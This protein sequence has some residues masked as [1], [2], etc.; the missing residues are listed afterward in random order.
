MI[1]YCQGAPGVKYKMLVA[2]VLKSGKEYQPHHVY[3]LRDMCKD[4]LPSHDF[5]CLT[6]AKLTGTEVIPLEH[7]WEG[8]WSKLELFKIEQPC[9]YFDLDTILVGDCTGIVDKAKDKPFVILRDFYRG[10]TLTPLQP[11]AMQSSMMYWSTSLKFMY[12]KFASDGERYPGGDQVL[13]EEAMK[14]KADMVHYWQ[15]LCTGIVSYKAHERYNGLQSTD[16]VV[17]FHG[18]PR[19]W[20]QK[21]IGYPTCK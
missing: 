3:N 6:D 12:D 8:W 10:Y 1:A 20:E 21:E 2:S 11:R 17:I 18:Q 15:D 19:P 14:D 13:I 7:E 4:F 5:V 9:L 16:R